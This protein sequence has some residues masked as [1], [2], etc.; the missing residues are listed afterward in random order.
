MKRTKGDLP[1]AART[2]VARPASPEARSVHLVAAGDHSNGF[3]GYDDLGRPCWSWIDDFDRVAD[4]ARAEDLLRAL[5]T[6]SLSLADEPVR[7]GGKENGYN[8]YDTARIKVGD[9]FKRR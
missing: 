4:E 6:D 5:D 9:R 1:A 8:P 7:R 2:D 3:L